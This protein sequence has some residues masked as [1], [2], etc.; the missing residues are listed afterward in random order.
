M[1]TAL[2]AAKRSKD[3]ISQVGACIVNMDQ[4]IVGVGYNG[5]PNGCGNELPW[6]ES[7]D[8]VNDKKF[9]GNNERFQLLKNQI[10][11]NV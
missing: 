10:I 9:Y 3:P 11:I 7:G 6:S 8:K 4:R 1:A 5:M 2:L